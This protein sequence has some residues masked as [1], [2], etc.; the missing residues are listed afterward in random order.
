MSIASAEVLLAC[1][2]SV[3]EVSDVRA[4]K[5]STPAGYSETGNHENSGREQ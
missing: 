5:G 1:E 4:S 2:R 3:S